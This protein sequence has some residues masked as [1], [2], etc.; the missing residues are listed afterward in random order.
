MDDSTTAELAQWLL[1][2][3][4]APASAA[5]DWCTL[6]ATEAAGCA[7]LCPS[8]AH[9][10][11]SDGAAGSSAP[12]ACPTPSSCRDGADPRD[13]IEVASE[14]LQPH[15]LRALISA[16]EAKHVGSRFWMG[17]TLHAAR[18]MRDEQ[19]EAA[20]VR[21]AAVS[22]HAHAQWPSLQ[23]LVLL[24]RA[25]ALNAQELAGCVHVGAATQADAAAALS[26]AERELRVLLGC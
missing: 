18:G 25:G 21:L 13:H 2:P 26:Y 19:A 7:A 23:C 9:S 24:L 10:A 15:E 16:R 22:A 12:E 20:R 6:S 17:S 8:V 14:P 1:E 3:A 5:D 11:R 4:A